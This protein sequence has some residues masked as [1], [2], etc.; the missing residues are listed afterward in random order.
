MFTH[1][2]GETNPQVRSGALQITGTLLQEIQ[3][4]REPAQQGCNPNF[5]VGF[6]IPR[7]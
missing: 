3:V 4:Q 7:A 6:P 1:N 5:C 2:G